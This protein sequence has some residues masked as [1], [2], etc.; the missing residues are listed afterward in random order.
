MW[1]CSAVLACSPAA[2]AGPPARFSV[3]NALGLARSEEVVEIPLR[4][5][6]A[7]A[8]VADAEGLVVRES[9]SG[10]V[11][12][13]QLYSS[14]GSGAPDLLLVL[15]GLAPKGSLDLVVEAGASPAAPKP[16]VYGRFVPERQDDFAWENDK[17]AFRMYGPALQKTGE[18]SSGV[19]VWVK[20]VPDLVI[21]DWYRKDLESAKR[22]DNAFS[23]HRDYGQGLDSYSVGPTLGCGGTAIW[24]GSKIIRSK[25]YV[26]WRVLAGGPIRFSVELT[27]A[28]WDANGVQVSETKRITLDAGSHLNRMESTFQAEGVRRLA[29]VAGVVMHP[30]AGLDT[31]PDASYISVWEPADDKTAGMIATGIVLPP[32]EKA[33]PKQADGHGVFLFQAR[34]GE[35]L[36]YYAGAGWS[37]SDI[38][39]QKAWDRY[40]AD[41][42]ARLRSPLRIQWK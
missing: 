1:I 33:E 12:P 5:V 31:A 7:H 24:D 9:A 39:D 15:V 40:L 42:A 38:P 21:D 30:G 8:R 28:P 36:G 14:G 11:L 3:I 10:K 18:I 34:P 37:K 27:Y 26:T 2:A 35:P 20:R 17:I 23:Y 25:N 32:G 4:D 6:L 16:L 13:T 29:A 19:D 41:F 22:R